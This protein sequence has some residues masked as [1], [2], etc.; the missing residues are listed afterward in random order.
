MRR[1]KC[2]CGGWRRGKTQPPVCGLLGKHDGMDGVAFS[3]FYIEDCWRP[4]S[5]LVIAT[6]SSTLFLPLGQGHHLQLHPLLPPCSPLRN[7]AVFS[8]FYAWKHG[9]GLCCCCTDPGSVCTLLNLPPSQ[10]R[11][12]S[13]RVIH[14]IPGQCLQQ[15]E[16]QPTHCSFP[17][18]TEPGNSFIPPAA[19][20]HTTETQWE[21]QLLP[22]RAE[23]PIGIQHL[24]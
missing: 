7:G 18:P 15:D 16:S 5:P 2:P 11:S 24:Y 20:I 12:D 1:E 17:Q 13:P 3:G 19:T 8:V 10:E 21:I 9:R 14:P 4:L 23:K 6:G 22:S